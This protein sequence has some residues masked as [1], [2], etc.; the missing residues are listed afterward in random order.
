VQTAKD[1]NEYI[2][3]SAFKKATKK[4]GE[5][6]VY[7]ILR[8]DAET[9]MSPI[10]KVIDDL[11]KKEEEKDLVSY[12]YVSGVYSDGMPWNGVIAK[13]MLNKSD[14]WK[15]V[16]K[17]SAKTKKVTDFVSD[18]KKEIGSTAKIAWNG[19]YILNAELVGKL[20]LPESYIGS[21]LG[22]LISNEKLLSAPLFN[23]PA[24]IFKKD[25]VHI[26]RVNCSKGII[27]SR[28]TSTVELSEDQYN[29]KYEKNKAVFYDLMYEQE[30][31]LV[32]DGIVIRLAGN[33]IKERIDVVEK[34]K[35]RIISVGL[36]LVIP[37][38][39]FSGNWKEND[40]LDIQVKGLENISY[41]IEACPMLIQNGKIV[42]DMAKE[43]WKTQNSI[44]TQ[45]ARLDYTV[46]IGPKIAAGIDNEGNLAVL[47]INGRIRESVGATHNN[48]A[49]ILKK[50]G[51]Q[52]AMGF[53]PG[54]S[55][56]LVVN[57]QTL[58]ISPY[59]SRYEEN[60]YALPPEPRAVSNVIIGYIKR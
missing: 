59:N 48:M 32:E 22:L 28:G 58:N 9:K 7:E 57:G 30:E 34:Q 47:T 8:K 56:T 5:E 27:V 44:K 43:G 14:E 37:K 46:M 35:I 41:A 40:E 53:D 52:Q 13:A 50:F 6:A 1:F 11:L 26:S 51:I 15:F 38:K 54:G 24:L 33:I 2:K 55:S 39:Y 42:L 45:A 18:L 4:Y 23:K 10:K 17:S 3:G 16:A 21:P 25:G 12:E 29:T 49:E 60:V 31:I 36:T 20:G 19:G